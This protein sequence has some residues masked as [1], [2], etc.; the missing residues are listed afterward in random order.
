MKSLNTK[1]LELA[2]ST[3]KALTHPLRMKILSYIDKNEPVHVTK[4]YKSLKLEQSVT[5]SHLKILRDASFLNTER[6][7]KRILYSVNND[8]IGELLDSI[9]TKITSKK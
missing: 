3:L 1:E 9:K 2:T 4:I 7:G 8:K 5:S 6:D